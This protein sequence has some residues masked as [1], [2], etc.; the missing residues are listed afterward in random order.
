MNRII[1]LTKLDK[2]PVF[3]Q[4]HLSVFYCT[5][6]FGCEDGRWMDLVLAYRMESNGGFDISGIEPSVTVLVICSD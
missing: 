6:L 4:K 5:F 1:D 3:I 2:V